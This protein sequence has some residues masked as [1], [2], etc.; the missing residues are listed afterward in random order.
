MEIE[1]ESTHTSEVASNRDFDVAPEEGRTEEWVNNS[2]QS[3]R[4]PSAQNMGDENDT[5][6]TGDGTVVTQ[7]E[8]QPTSEVVT[9]YESVLS[10]APCDQQYPVSS[11]LSVHSAP[12]GAQLSNDPANELEVSGT[13]LPGRSPLQETGNH[14]VV[15]PHGITG[16]IIVP[17]VSSAAQVTIPAPSQPATRHIVPN[18]S[19]W[20]FPK[21]QPPTLQVSSTMPNNPKSVSAYGTGAVPY[22]SGGTVYYPPVP[23]PT[24]VQASAPFPPNTNVLP[25]TSVAAATPA[26]SQL[27][28]NNPVTIK[29]LAELLTISREDP[30]PEWKLESYDRNPLQWH[31]WFGQFRS[32]VDCAPLSPDVKL[33]YLKTLVTGR[34]KLAIANFAYCGSM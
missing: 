20:N 26:S 32:A 21:P 30:L 18:L 16:R 24:V 9:D 1:A 7:I 19:S 25:S 6:V 2:S 13:I 3:V 27:P 11:R 29:D 28:G 5:Q 23:N 4:E 8:R 14:N 10:S 33:T 34:A 17:P 31:E 15:H 22:T 12:T